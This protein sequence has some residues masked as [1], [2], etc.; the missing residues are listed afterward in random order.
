MTDLSVI[1]TSIKIKDIK[2]MTKAKQ[3]LYTWGAIGL[4]IGALLPKVL[5]ADMYAKLAELI[6][7]EVS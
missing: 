1:L 4:A 6:G 5:P 2:I 7:L 3:K